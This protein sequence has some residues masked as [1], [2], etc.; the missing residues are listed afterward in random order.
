MAVRS[1]AA[2]SATIRAEI[3]GESDL[4]AFFL[5]ILLRYLHDPSQRVKLRLLLWVTG[6]FQSQNSNECGQSPQIIIL[7]AK[8]GVDLLIGLPAR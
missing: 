5:A 4:S 2:V 3:G 8:E 7:A 6:P 1:R